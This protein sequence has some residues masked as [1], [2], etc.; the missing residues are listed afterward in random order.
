MIFNRI[1]IDESTGVDFEG[2]CSTLRS[3]A[4][5]LEMD[6]N[7]LVLRI[8]QQLIDEEIGETEENEESSSMPTAVKSTL[9]TRREQKKDYFIPVFV[10]VAAGPLNA[11]F[12]SC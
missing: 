1:C 10:A 4:S 9:R 11:N 2:F 12:C 7:Q 3:L 6:T 8:Q 5:D